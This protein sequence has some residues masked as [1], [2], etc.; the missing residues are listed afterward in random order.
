MTKVHFLD[1]TVLL[2]VVPLCLM[3]LHLVP[4]CLMALTGCKALKSSPGLSKRGGTDE[5]PVPAE[6]LSVSHYPTLH[7]GPY[8]LF[9]SKLRRGYT[10]SI[11]DDDGAT[12]TDLFGSKSPVALFAV[13][14]RRIFQL[15]GSTGSNAR[16]FQQFAQ[17]LGNA[18]KH[19]DMPSAD[20]CFDATDNDA[21]IMDNLRDARLYCASQITWLPPVYPVIAVPNA[22]YERSLLNDHMATVP[23][24]QKI[25]KVFW[26]GMLTGTLGMYPGKSKDEFFNLPRVRAFQLAQMHPGMWDFGFNNIDDQFTERYMRSHWSKKQAEF[27]RGIQ[28]QTLSNFSVELPRFKY[29]L[30]VDGI[31]VSWR[32]RDLL[33][34]GSV[35][36]HFMGK[37]AEF[38]F[39][40]L[41]PWEHYVPVHDLE[42]VP[43]LYRQ[44]EADEALA[45]RIAR[46]GRAFADARLTAA[47]QDC[48]LYRALE[49]VGARAAYELADPGALRRIGFVEVGA[50]R[51]ASRYLVDHAGR[52]V[53]A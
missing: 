26:R 14:G 33:R 22:Y 36:F 13:R 35:V 37:S 4:L 45:R 30:N 2:D 11:T 48:Y 23:W 49:F 41:K 38:F 47:G 19:H 21:F 17:A 44:L 12:F 52:T 18:A 32:L 28:F 42:D 7:E 46:A 16:A 43:G 6:L 9:P 51:G 8:M 50:R 39:R 40:D 31:V 24:E 3:A 53:T 10:V 15:G 27:I 25:P 34:S 29:L 5:C 1:F 20:F